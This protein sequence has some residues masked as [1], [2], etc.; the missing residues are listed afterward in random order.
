MLLV[1]H[2]KE[3]P[4]SSNVDPVEPPEPLEPPE[5]VSLDLPLKTLLQTESIPSSCNLPGGE[6]RRFPPSDF[7]LDRFLKGRY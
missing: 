4:I 6:K 7:P 1:Y 5:A 2:S 3:I